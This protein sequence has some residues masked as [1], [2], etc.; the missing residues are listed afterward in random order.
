MWRQCWNGGVCKLSCHWSIFYE[1]LIDNLSLNMSVTH[2]FKVWNFYG[3]VQMVN[4]HE[5]RKLLQ[6]RQNWQAWKWTGNIKSPQTGWLNDDLSDVVHG[7]SSQVEQFVW[8]I[9]IMNKT[10][11]YWLVHWLHICITRGRLIEMLT[12]R[13]EGPK[14]P[15]LRNSRFGGHMTSLTL[16]HLWP[17]P[18]GAWLGG[19]GCKPGHSGWS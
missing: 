7:R 8:L 4:W 12:I 19:P 2:K 5:N 6:Q 9:L 15:H 10:L 16:Q 11:A 3:S 1:I 17:K 14:D 13:L 18:P